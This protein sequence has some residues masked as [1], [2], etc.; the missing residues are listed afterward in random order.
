MVAGFREPEPR[1][2]SLSLRHPHDRLRPHTV[3]IAE[4]RQHWHLCPSLCS[5]SLRP[6]L[7]ATPTLVRLLSQIK[8]GTDLLHRTV[9]PRRQLADVLRVWESAHEGEDDDC[10]AKRDQERGGGALPLRR[11]CVAQVRH[12]HEAEIPTDFAAQPATRRLRL[13]ACAPPSQTVRAGFRSR[14]WPDPRS[15]ASG[16]A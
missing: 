6:V 11:A 13:C 12:R 4:S 2:I 10:E 8:Q 16:S 1:V 3:D 7:P 9:L 5:G 14:G 15:R